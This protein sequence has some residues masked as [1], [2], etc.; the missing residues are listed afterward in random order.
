MRI[1]LITFFIFFGL[2]FSKNVI[3]LSS[4]TQTLVGPRSNIASSTPTDYGFWSFS[5]PVK[6]I[7]ARSGQPTILEFEWLRKQGFKSVINLRQENEYKEVADDEKLSGFKKLG[8]NYL[9]LQIRD[10][11][12]PTDKQAQD[13]LKFVKNKKNWPILIHCRAGIGRTGLMTALYR[14]EV[15]KWTMDT[16]IKES[17]L[18]RGGVNSIQ[19]KWLLNWAKKYPKK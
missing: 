14:Y 2:L 5:I 7:L 17:R 8:F 4:N 13:F 9:R 18:F 6:N 11:G 1:K 10:G 15:Q 19:K 3:A 12:I 16:A